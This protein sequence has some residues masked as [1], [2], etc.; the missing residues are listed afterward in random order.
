MRPGAMGYS[1]E[2]RLPST[3]P[4]PAAFECWIDV[5]GSGFGFVHQLRKLGSEI[6]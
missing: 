2:M 3:T 6:A 4:Q 1:R 5:L